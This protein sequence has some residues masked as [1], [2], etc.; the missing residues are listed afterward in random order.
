MAKE[1]GW[2]KQLESEPCTCVRCS[3]CCGTGTVYVDMSGAEC[4]YM[5]EDTDSPEPCE[6]C[7]NGVVEICETEECAEYC[8]IPSRNFAGQRRARSGR[9][10]ALGAA[11]S[12]AVPKHTDK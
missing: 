3:F 10:P 8:A 4:P 12:K 7:R 5:F 1:A 9:D 6:E 2:I 11:L